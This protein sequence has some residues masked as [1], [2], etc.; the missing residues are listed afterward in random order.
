MSLNLG[1]ELFVCSKGLRFL[2]YRDCF[3]P[4]SHIID[5]V[6]CIRFPPIDVVAV[7]PQRLVCMHSP[8]FLA[9]LEAFSGNSRWCSLAWAQASQKGESDASSISMLVIFLADI[10]CFTAV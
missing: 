9:L 4:S 8:K 10:T 6:D 7:G 5:E 3:C 1:F 2:L